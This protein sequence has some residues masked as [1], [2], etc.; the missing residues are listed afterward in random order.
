MDVDGTK[1]AW[2]HDRN[3]VTH[4]FTEFVRDATATKTNFRVLMSDTAEASI[5]RDRTVKQL[6]VIGCEYEVPW[7]EM[8]AIAPGARVVDDISLTMRFQGEPEWSVR[9]GLNT[10]EHD[11]NV[12]YTN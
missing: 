5:R 11:V 1:L 7:E 9:V 10:V 8:Y 2:L 4:S 3:P 6:C 12:Q